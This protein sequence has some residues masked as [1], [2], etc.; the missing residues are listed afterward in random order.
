M[1]SSGGK[2]ASVVF[3][4]KI[5]H[6]TFPLTHMPAVASKMMTP[7]AKHVQ[8]GEVDYKAKIDV[9]IGEFTTKVTSAPLTM[10]FP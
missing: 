2:S 10:R 3:L 6:Q 4:F 7:K 9:A 8:G 1:Y 5:Y